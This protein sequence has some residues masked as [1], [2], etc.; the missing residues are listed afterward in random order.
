MAEQKLNITKEE[1]IGDKIQ[2]ERKRQ[3]LTQQALAS[4]AEMPY[5]T[6]AKIEGNAITRPTIQTVTKIAV[7]LNISIDK[8]VE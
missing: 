1:T 7:G 3:G 5:S 4:K 2:R 8:L 6:I